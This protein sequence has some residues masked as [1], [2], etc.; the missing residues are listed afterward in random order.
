MI[1][2]IVGDKKRAWGLVWAWVMLIYSTLYIVRPICAFLEKTTPF[3]QLTTGMIFIAF[4]AVIIYGIVW[5]HLRRPSTFVLLALIG[6]CYVYGVMVIPFPA[7]K[8]HFLQY[9]V[10]AFLCYRALRAD[11]SRRK[12]YI[13]AILL[14]TVFGWIDEGIQH[15]LPNR[16][17]ELRDVALNSIS[18]VLGL[19]LVFIFERERLKENS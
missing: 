7:E 3:N 14:T 11:F 4:A 8:I 13:F 9:G 19:F 18:G 1:N 6:V 17:Y 5:L 12:A 10:L 2:R 15:L 16:Y